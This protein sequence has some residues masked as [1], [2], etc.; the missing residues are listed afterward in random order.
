M[1]VHLDQ[2]IRFLETQVQVLIQ[3]SNQNP[4]PQV[5]QQMVQR[6]QL[7][8][9]KSDIQKVQ[10]ATLQTLVSALLDELVLAGSLR[11]NIKEIL[12]ITTKMAE[13]TS[14]PKELTHNVPFE[15]D[16]L[17]GQAPRTPYHYP[18]SP[19]LSPYNTNPIPYQTPEYFNN[20]R[21]W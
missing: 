4:D 14:L 11:D 13:Q 19:P 21:G 15:V 3:R 12:D 7:A 18:N 17:L 6:L 10:I 9:M 1:D 8:E 2:R 20:A 16:K 5:L